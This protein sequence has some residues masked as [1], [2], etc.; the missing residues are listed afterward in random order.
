MK[1]SLRM[2]VLKNSIKSERKNSKNFNI[3]NFFFERILL[4]SVGR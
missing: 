1:K 4:P 2:I 3:E